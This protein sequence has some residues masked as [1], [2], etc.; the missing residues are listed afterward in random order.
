MINE[1]T[2]NVA[3]AKVTFTLGIPQL[4]ANNGGFS[5][6][7]TALPTSVQ[8]TLSAGFRVHR[9]RAQVKITPEVTGIGAA[10]RACYAWTDNFTIQVLIMNSSGVL[11]QN[12]FSIAIYEIARQAGST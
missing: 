2:V 4:T 12:G 3:R 8:L 7:A 1:K 11:V 10:R 5:A 9:N 6:V